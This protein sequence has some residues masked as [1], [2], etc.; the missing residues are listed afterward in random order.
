MNMLSINR[1]KLIFNKYKV[2]GMI[3]LGHLGLVRRCISTR[4][5][6]SCLGSIRSSQRGWPYSGNLLIHDREI[7]TNTSTTQMKNNTLITLKR[8]TKWENGIPIGNEPPKC[9]YLVLKVKLALSSSSKVLW[10]RWN[11]KTEKVEKGQFREVGISH[12]EVRRC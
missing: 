9:N 3:T 8:A 4:G 10:W 2:G 6:T 5:A 1:L 7:P 11:L 12:V